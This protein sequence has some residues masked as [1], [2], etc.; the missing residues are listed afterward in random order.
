MDLVSFLSYRKKSMVAK[1]K[2]GNKEAFLEIINENRANIYRVA[3]G[4]LR[5]EEDIEDAIQNTIINAY[6]NIKTLKKDEYFKTWITRI[7]INECNSIFRKNK[8]FVVLEEEGQ[9]NGYKDD[10][11]NIDL[12]RAINSL[13]EELKATV[14]LFYF[15]DMTTK[16]IADILD[17]PEGTVRS[18][19]TR[20]R[21]KLREIMGEE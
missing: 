20:A 14:V 2:G 16:E 18:R 8:R 19:L 6:E 5:N 3:K 4:I 21:G 17:V 1:A 10:Y 15:E 13:N 9:G 7:L 12:T 11:E